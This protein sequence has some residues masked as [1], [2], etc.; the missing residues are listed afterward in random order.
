MLITQD[1]DRRLI[2]RTVEMAQQNGGFSARRLSVA[3]DS[4]PLW[5][6]ARAEDNFNLWGHELRKTLGAIAHDLIPSGDC[7]GVLDIEPL[8]AI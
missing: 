8:Q 4:N 2:E 3:L 6:A 5:G 1:F 7:L